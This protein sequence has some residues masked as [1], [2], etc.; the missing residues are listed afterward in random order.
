MVT[1]PII[2]KLR[3]ELNNPNVRKLIGKAKSLI[4]G[5]TKT[6]TRVRKNINTAAAVILAISKVGRIFDNIIKTIILVK[7]YRIIL[8]ILL[9]VYTLCIM[10]SKTIKLDVKSNLEGS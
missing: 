7:K 5:A 1:K 10:L 4:I 3:T 8:V 6:F 9:Y 2:S